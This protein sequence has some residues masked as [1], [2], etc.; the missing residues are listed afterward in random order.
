MNET[1]VLKTLTDYTDIVTNIESVYKE[2]CDKILAADQ[3]E[4]DWLHKI[5]MLDHMPDMYECYK[6]IQFI[7]TLREQRRIAKNSSYAIYK[8]FKWVSG[9]QFIISEMKTQKKSLEDVLESQ[10]DIIYNKRYCENSLLN[11]K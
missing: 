10:K 1:D 3:M 4:F 6:E 2:L 7:K 11:P 9:H 5:E 8:L